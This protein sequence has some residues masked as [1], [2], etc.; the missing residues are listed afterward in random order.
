M[1]SARWSTA[2]KAREWGE[3]GEGFG[4]EGLKKQVEFSTLIIS[5][6]SLGA[7]GEIWPSSQ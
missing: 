3:R 7:S 6:P 5:L 1:K 2:M 4:S